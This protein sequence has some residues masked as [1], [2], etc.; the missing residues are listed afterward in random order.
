[1]NIFHN[2]F[3]IE[4]ETKSI[5]DIPMCPRPSIKS[6]SPPS[7]KSCL[8]LLVSIAIHS[9]CGSPVDDSGQRQMAS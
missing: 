3:C 5:L 8:I 4:E 1:M 7:S 2:P 9:S 6:T